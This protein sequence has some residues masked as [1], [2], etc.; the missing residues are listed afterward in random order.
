MIQPTIKQIADVFVRFVRYANLTLGG[1]SA[2][3]AVIHG[4][5][6]IITTPRRS[7]HWRSAAI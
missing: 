4:E 7:K 6:S 1:G 5:G 3:T 2:R